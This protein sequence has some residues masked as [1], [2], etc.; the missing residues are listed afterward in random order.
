MNLT[1][2]E[3]TRSTAGNFNFHRVNYNSS[4]KTRTEEEWRTRIRAKC[5][6]PRTG[7]TERSLFWFL[8]DTKGKRG[9]HALC[10]RKVELPTPSSGVGAGAPRQGAGEGGVA[11]T[12][13]GI[14]QFFWPILDQL[15]HV[16][17]ARA[18]PN[19]GSAPCPWAQMIPPVKVMR[20]EFVSFLLGSDAPDSRGFSPLWNFLRQRNWGFYIDA[21]TAGTFSPSDGYQMPLLEVERYVPPVLFYFILPKE[22]NRN[23]SLKFFVNIFQQVRK[24]HMIFLRGNCLIFFYENRIS[25]RAPNP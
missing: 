25:K 23:I 6:N 10:N 17:M 19:V 7:T 3:A 8:L 14:A 20:T 15:R 12:H 13:G 4:T 22:T 16:N 18:L 9:E 1:Q 21:P 5:S 2:R 24:I 11:S